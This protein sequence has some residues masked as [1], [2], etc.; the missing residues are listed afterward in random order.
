MDSNN[1]QKQKD[2]QNNTTTPSSRNSQEIPA[3][4]RTQKIDVYKSLNIGWIIL[5]LA[6]WITITL[7][8]NDTYTPNKTVWDFLYE[9]F[10]KR[11][12]AIILFIAM[13]CFTWLYS[14]TVVDET[15]P[16]I[17]L[18]S[19]FGIISVVIEL[20]QQQIYS[21]SHSDDFLQMKVIGVLISSLLLSILFY[22]LQKPNI[23]SVNNQ[24]H[25]IGYLVFNIIGWILAFGWTLTQKN[26]HY[27]NIFYP[28]L[29]VIL[30]TFV[31]AYVNDYWIRDYCIPAII[32]IVLFLLLLNKFFQKKRIN[33][34]WRYL[35]FPHWTH[36]Y[37][38]NFFLFFYL[39]Y[40]FTLTF[41]NKT[42]PNN[43]EIPPNN[44]I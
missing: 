7:I 21:K 34:P 43:N 28:V 39:C 1:L 32:G 12:V 30:F 26:N 6:Y 36:I 10:K 25:N 22:N 24:H 17:Y 18:I 9:L 14:Q 33:N 19:I 38:Y 5:T 37:L 41:Y 27:L 3:R 8:P 35:I 31:T 44:E 13:S 2:T 29:P 4:T 15:L 40:L 11:W 23:S 42:P 16:A 20:L